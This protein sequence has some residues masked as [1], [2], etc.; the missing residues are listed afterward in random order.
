MRG[1]T[2]YVVLR[3][4]QTSCGVII[5]LEKANEQNSLRA[6]YSFDSL[7]LRLIGIVREGQHELIH[8]VGHRARGATSQSMMSGT[9]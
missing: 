7:H 3:A 4:V 6:N 8:T 5:E 9:G 1:A 2:R